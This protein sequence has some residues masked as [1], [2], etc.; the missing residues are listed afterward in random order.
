MA[1]SVCMLLA[2]AL[3]GLPHEMLITDDGLSMLTSFFSSGRSLTA[4]ECEGCAL[5]SWGE[6]GMHALTP[7]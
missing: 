4:R 5:A 1:V 6:Q 2:L 3:S 7:P